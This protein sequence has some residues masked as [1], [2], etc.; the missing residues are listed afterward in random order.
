MCLPT[1]RC[2][3]YFSKE[4]RDLLSMTLYRLSTLL[5]KFCD[6][7]IT[8]FTI[9][10]G[11]SESGVQPCGAQRSRRVSPFNLSQSRRRMQ[12]FFT[13]LHYVQNDIIQF[14]VDRVLSTALAKF[15]DI[16]LFVTPFT[17]SGVK[18]CAVEGSRLSISVRQEGECRDSFTPLRSVQNDILHLLA[19]SVLSV[20]RRKEVR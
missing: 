7:V 11:T 6:T 13:S 8:L 2:Q 4:V 10:E 17:K 5:A 19:D 1:L 18:P 12:R 3:A 9:P 20:V 15:C 16:D 14:L